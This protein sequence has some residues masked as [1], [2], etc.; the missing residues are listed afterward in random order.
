MAE[1]TPSTSGSGNGNAN[2]EKKAHSNRLLI[3]IIIGAALGVVAGLI[4]PAT[5]DRTGGMA[6]EGI[7]GVKFLGDMFLHM[8]FMIVVPLIMTSMIVGVASLGD[9][10]KIGRVGWVTLAFYFTTTVIAVVI[11]MTLAAIFRPGGGQPHQFLEP[12]ATAIP[13][14][15]RLAPAGSP[16]G[17]DERQ[18]EITLPP[19][20]REFM[21]VQHTPDVKA[22][23][24]RILGDGKP[25]ETNV[26][27]I[28]MRPD[29]KA[30]GLVA[31]DDFDPSGTWLLTLRNLTATEAFATLQH[32]LWGVDRAKTMERP[33]RLHIDRGSADSPVMRTFAINVPK[34]P[35]SMTLQL[36]G[37]NPQLGFYV[38]YGEPIKPEE[39]DGW[40]YHVK[41][42]GELRIDSSK[43]VAIQQGSWFVTV[44]NTGE[45]ADAGLRLLIDAEAH[46]QTF[47][48]P[49]MSVLERVIAF[50]KD[51]A[52]RIFPENLFDAMKQ[53]PNVL[54]LIIFALLL[55]GILTTLGEKGKPVIAF[56]EGL[57]EA[58]MKF[59]GLV[60]WFA[61]V[62]IFALV[63]TKIGASR[64]L[65]A[66]M[67]KLAAYVGVVIGGLGIHA[68]IVLPFLL[69]LLTGR[70]PLKYAIGMGKALVTAFSTAS[71][72]ATLPLNLECAIDD[73][74][75]S[76]KASEFVIPLGATVNMDGTALYEAVAVIFMAQMLGV[77]LD[78]SAYVIISITA[79]LA[80]IGAAGIPEAGTVTMV[81][82]LMAVGLPADAVG[83]ILAIDWFLDRCRTTVNVWGDSVA[84]AVVDVHALGAPRG[85]PDDPPAAAATPAA[86]PAPA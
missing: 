3:Y 24:Q 13:D 7:T 11:G 66:E 85:N 40:V 72:N 57:F 82:V 39:M 34:K 64:D 60:M 68:L 21:I 12:A 2:G 41:G 23:F 27:D 75:V 26:G 20:T 80:A 78:F 86:T 28:T 43:V 8:L 30:V 62:G 18:Y 65:L 74:K 46:D 42:N 4:W 32:T 50:V 81:M 59:V 67:Q 47:I 1:E 61:P 5:Y 29:V 10:R 52:E 58:V 35:K 49:G 25:D 84:A 31:S 16:D 76:R 38:R 45:A 9:V 55:G 37:A 44:V 69:R 19:G 71:S 36:S 15:V 79:T 48:R 22:T 70:S 56:A 17:R 77:P 51:F 6:S 53:P 83:Y 33:R 63:A 14:A 73:N 54:A